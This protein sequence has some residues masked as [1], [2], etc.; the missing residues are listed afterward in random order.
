LR[1]DV[2]ILYWRSLGIDAARS[3]Q[4]GRLLS[5]DKTPPVK[6]ERHALA[7]DVIHPCLKR[8]RDVVV[9]D[10]CRDDKVLSHK[11]FGD[12]FIG[13]SKLL[14]HRL[15]LICGRCE[16]G[17]EPRR[18]NETEP[19]IGEIAMHDVTFRIRS[20]PCRKEALGHLTRDGPVAAWAGLDNEKLVHLR[21]LSFGMGE[22]YTGCRW[23]G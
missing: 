19:G 10:R 23:M 16:V 22:Q 18:C 13:Q 15:R 14:F 3:H 21:V 4:Q 12:Q 9:V 20:A 17:L 1:R 8:G 5:F 7:Y 6:A 11:E 2:A